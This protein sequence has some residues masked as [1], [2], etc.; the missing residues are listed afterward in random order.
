MDVADVCMD[1]EDAGEALGRLAR[2]ERVRA[3]FQEGFVKL[4]RM[5]G[6]LCAFLPLSFFFLLHLIEARNGPA[7]FKTST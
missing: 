7:S 1:G 6:K 5:Q 3:R 2:F 4:A